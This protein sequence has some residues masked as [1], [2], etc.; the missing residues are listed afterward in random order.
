MTAY[1][2]TSSLLN[3]LLMAL[4]SM[5]FV[6]MAPF[7]TG[8]HLLERVTSRLN[9]PLYCFLIAKPCCSIQD[10]FLLECSITPVHPTMNLRKPHSP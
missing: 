9:I 3:T 10:S 2:Q 7:R 8:Q 4:S 1:V 5:I 6:M